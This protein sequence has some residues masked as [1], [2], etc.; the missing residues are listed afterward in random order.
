MI[1]FV[2]LK[3]IYNVLIISKKECKIHLFYVVIYNIRSK[4][5]Q[6]KMF[7]RL[8]KAKFRLLFIIRSTFWITYSYFSHL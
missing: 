2:L 6:K 3:Y 8:L 4:H 5:L 7:F 1:N